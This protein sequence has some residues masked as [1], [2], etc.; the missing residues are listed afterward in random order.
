M[1]AGSCTAKV[2]TFAYGDVA[3]GL[4]NGDGTTVADVEIVE[5]LEPMSVIGT[6]PPV[7]L[8]TSETPSVG[9]S[10]ALGSG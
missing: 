8:Y 6:A 2:V 10:L 3:A 1:R 5:P 9:T 7:L 4:G